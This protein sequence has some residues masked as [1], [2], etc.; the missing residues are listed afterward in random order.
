MMQ[1]KKI[2]NFSIRNSNDGLDFSSLMC[3]APAT[4]QNRV[5]DTSGQ[6]K[7]HQKKNRKPRRQHKPGI[8]T[9]EQRKAVE[10]AQNKERGRGKVKKGRVNVHFAADSKLVDQIKRIHFELGVTLNQL[11]NEAFSLLV[12]KYSKRK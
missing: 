3:P 12:Q 7:E 10:A 4:K 8:V 1:N 9:P 5:P 6:P 2:G 11:F